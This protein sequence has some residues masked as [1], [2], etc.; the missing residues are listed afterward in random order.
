MP[1]SAE[2]RPKPTERRTD[3]NRYFGGLMSRWKRCRLV[4]SASAAHIAVVTRNRFVEAICLPCLAMICDS[5]PPFQCPRKLGSGMPA[6]PFGPRMTEVVDPVGSVFDASAEN[7][8]RTP[9]ARQCSV[10]RARRRTRRR[11]PP[12]SLD[13]HRS[14]P[15]ARLARKHDAMPPS[16]LLERLVTV[17]STMSP[18]S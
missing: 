10:A 1:K 4:R 2:L 9:L 6:T 15:A 11:A 3:P 18:R 8:R 5:V 14:R 13:S 17:K 7:K 12:E 16:R